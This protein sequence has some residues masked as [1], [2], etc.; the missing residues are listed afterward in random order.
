[1]KV[2][3]SERRFPPGV[4]PAF[5]GVLGGKCLSKYS[6]ERQGPKVTLFRELFLV[7]LKIELPM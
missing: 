4:D 7:A 6:G 5:T 2:A 1:M 3:G